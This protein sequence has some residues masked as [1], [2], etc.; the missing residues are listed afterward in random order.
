LYTNDDISLDYFSKYICF[1][2]NFPTTHKD[3]ISFYILEEDKVTLLFLLY[4]QKVE[5][6]K[7][8]IL[9]QIKDNHKFT[10]DLMK[11]YFTLNP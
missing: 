11:I 6:D 5:L 9:R 2:Q 3:K 1:K 7:K 10:E 4:F 8:H